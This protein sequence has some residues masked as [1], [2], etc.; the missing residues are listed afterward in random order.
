MTNRWIRFLLAVLAI[1]AAAAAA[2]RI[3]Q[4]EQLLAGDVVAGRNTDSAAQTAIA[5]TEELRAALHAYVAPGQS[6]AFW[7]ARAAQL[8][9]KLRTSLLEL[10]AASNANGS[11]ISGALDTCD[12]LSAAEQ[13]AREYARHEEPLLA[14]EVIFNEG[15]DLLDGLRLQIARNADQLAKVSSERQAAVRK[16]QMLLAAGAAGILVFA[17]LLLVPVAR[18][19]TAG[20]PAQTRVA[21]TPVREAARA[22]DEPAVV[23]YSPAATGLSIS[24][25]SD[26][27]RLCSDLAATEDTAEME[28]LLESARGL[29][30]AR[31]II[32]WMSTSDRT[33]LEAAVIS[34]YDKRLITRLGTIPA[35]GDNVTAR[36]FRENDSRTSAAT[37][38]A[39]ASLA[40]PLPSPRGAAGVLAAELKPDVAVDDAKVV[41]AR[42]IAAELGALIAARPSETADKPQIAAD[43]HR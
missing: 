20:V 26:V 18:H 40:V 21:E 41:I 22:R 11:S 32:V 34:G 14:A 8:L 33:A 36:A 23:A 16:E 42:L 39:A 43:N 35:D 5:R 3:V 27:A 29:L 7:T 28:H 13:R 19:T 2:Y 1:G 15:R 6:Y 31:G 12:R 38:T 4:D 17:L 10:D 30:N 24:R 37:A 9:D 25:A